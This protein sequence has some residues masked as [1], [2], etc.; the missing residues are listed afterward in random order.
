MATGVDPKDQER[1]DASLA[2]I[3][4]RLLVFSGKGGVG[5]TTVAVNLAAGLARAGLRVGVLDADIHGP[6]TAKMLGVERAEPGI[7]EGGKMKPA[8]SPDGVKVMSMAMLMPSDDAPVVWRGPMKMSV[9]KQ[10]ITD[11]D[12]GELDWLIIDSPPGTGDEPLTVAQ[13]IPATAAIVVTTPQAV[14]LLD[15]RK[16]LNFALL[17]KLRVIGVV[18]NMSG[19]ACPHCGGQID[20]FKRDGGAQMAREML[21]PLLGRIPIDPAIVDDGDTGR[22][23]VVSQP[24]SAASKAM[25]DI[26]RR[27]IEFAAMKPEKEEK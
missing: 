2:T 1:L 21:V 22:P 25:A 8:T 16:A 5:K 15:S 3:H 11:V 13:L 20:L 18:E 7:S 19:L 24:E 9:I 10:F 27:V 26:V 23:F 12:W 6:N 17:L 14:A 4:N